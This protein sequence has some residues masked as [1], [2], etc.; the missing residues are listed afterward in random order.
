MN[1]TYRNLIRAEHVWTV[2]SEK[3]EDIQRAWYSLDSQATE[4]D[5]LL[6]TIVSDSREMAER[7]TLFAKDVEAK[8]YTHASTPMGYS[9]GNDIATN[10]A[11]YEA[12]ARVFADCFNQLTSKRVGTAIEA[13]KTS[14]RDEVTP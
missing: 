14:R 7:F 13:Y 9:T 2:L 6:A 8:G 1:F 10:A 4:L 5:R 12:L 3:N 11:R